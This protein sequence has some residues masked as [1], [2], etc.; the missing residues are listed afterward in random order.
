ME[1]FQFHIMCAT[2]ATIGMGVA[3]SIKKLCRKTKVKRQARKRAW[4][5][6]ENARECCGF[7]VSF[8]IYCCISINI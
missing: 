3:N 1:P 6:Q 8:I 5:P 7:L 4:S 2:V